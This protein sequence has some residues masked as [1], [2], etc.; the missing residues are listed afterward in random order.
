MLDAPNPRCAITACTPLKAPAAQAGG[1]VASKLAVRLAN[2]PC[3]VACV[4]GVASAAC[5]CSVNLDAFSAF[6]TSD[7]I[8]PSCICLCT[9]FSN[10][11]AVPW[12]AFKSDT[13]DLVASAAFTF[14][15]GSVGSTCDAVIAFA[16]A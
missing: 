15:L 12:A 6:A 4:D 7:I 8:S 11:I 3:T 9:G 5:I 14:A 10:F 1:L 16:V 2:C 13:L